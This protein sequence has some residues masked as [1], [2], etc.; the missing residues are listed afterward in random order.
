MIAAV[1]AGMFGPM[2]AHAAQLISISGLNLAEDE[3]IAAIDIRTWGVFVRAVCS[4]PPGWKI[5][6]GKEID[7]GGEVSGS[8]SGF[9]ANLNRK[10][11]AELENM[12]L[13]ADPDPAYRP[14]STAIPMFNGAIS[15]GSYKKPEAG[16]HDKKLEV[17]NF[18]LTPAKGCPSP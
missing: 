10:Q 18:I 14:P 11:L 4:I 12:F 16:E 9:V 17:G 2:P 5:T 13:I 8:A 15:I 7:P 6:A 1:L 3:Y